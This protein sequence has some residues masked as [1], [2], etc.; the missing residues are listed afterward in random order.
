MRAE[1]ASKVQKVQQKSNKSV[2]EKEKGEYSQ[3]QM[4]GIR[5]EGKW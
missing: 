5:E 2:K 3:P 4:K 1:I